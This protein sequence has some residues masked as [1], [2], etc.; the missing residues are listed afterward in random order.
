MILLSIL[1]PFVKSRS[2][3]L[4]DLIEYLDEQIGA[5][6]I[7]HLTF[8]DNK[9][10]SVGG[11]RNALL[12]IAQG[13]YITYVDDDDWVDP[14]YIKTVY[15]A[16][17]DHDPDVLTFEQIASFDGVRGVVQFRHG[18]ENEQ[19]DHTKVTKRAAWHAC[20]WRTSIARLSRFSDV[21]WGEDWAWAEPL[22]KL[23]LKEHH[24]PA[25]LHEYRFSTKGSEAHYDSLP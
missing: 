15:Q 7:E 17:V 10:R 2:S 20:V 23:R 16:L 21:N 8:G 25:T 4:S 9:R 12:D 24:V 3:Q 14:D 5:L 1:T 13:K 19:F 11:K 6:P 22:N 18:Q